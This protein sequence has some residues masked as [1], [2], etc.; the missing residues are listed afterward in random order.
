MTRSELLIGGA[1]QAAAAGGATRPV[2]SPYHGR[3]VGEVA[4]AGPDDVERAIRAAETGAARWRRTPAH[5]RSDILLR[6][7]ALADE[8]A[9]RIG[10]ILSAE[11]GK[12]LAEARGEARR[13]GDI[14]R[15]AAYEG[16]RLYGETPPLVDLPGSGV[17][18]DVAPAEVSEQEWVAPL[19]EEYEQGL[20]EQR[21]HV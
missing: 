17:F 9:D 13:S 10:E 11:N 4:S 20:A 3:T 16:T 14:I 5:E 12:T 1:W 15:L 19:R 6:A 7:A 2:T 18:W 21:W 8:R